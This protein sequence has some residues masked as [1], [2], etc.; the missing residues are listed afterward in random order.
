[1]YGDFPAKNTVY[2]RY[3]PI[4]VWFWPTLGVYSGTKPT[5]SIKHTHLVS[6]S[7]S[8]P[9]RNTLRLQT[10]PTYCMYTWRSK[11]KG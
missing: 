7:N 8:L 11:V 1:M 4:N 10:S 5:K 2:T 3:I 9:A 6:S